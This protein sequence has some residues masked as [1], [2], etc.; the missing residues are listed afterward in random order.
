MARP[1]NTKARRE[2]IVSGFQSALAQFGYE[3]ATISS[4]AKAAG[5]TTGLIHYHFKSKQEIFLALVT[6]LGE[7]LNERYH[8]MCAKATSPEEKLT[9]FLNSR[10]ATGKD[11]DPEAVACWVAIGAEALRQPEVREVYGQAMHRQMSQLVEILGPLTSNQEQAREIAAAL[12]ASIEGCYQLASA[13]PDL[14]T[15]GFAARSVQK[16][17]EGLLGCQLPSARE[18]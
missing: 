2:Q 9:A 7:S 6:K 3:K 12:L 5:L 14:V 13:V 1:S 8:T 18:A 11:Q 16:M 17:A 4:I 10:L 15:P